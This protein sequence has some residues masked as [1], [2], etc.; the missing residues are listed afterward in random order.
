MGHVRDRLG[1]KRRLPGDERGALELR[2]PRE[3]A[4]AKACVRAGNAGIRVEPVDVDQHRRCRQPH[5]ERRHEALAAGEEPGI[6][7]VRR[8]E[9][10]DVCQRLGAH[11]G[12]GRGF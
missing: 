6:G 4:D 1:E 3:R 9:L 11:V 2:V 10:V 5:V 12:E 7:S 8:E